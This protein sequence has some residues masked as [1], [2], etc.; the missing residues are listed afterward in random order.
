MEAFRHVD[1]DQTIVFGERALE[2]AGD[3]CSGAGGGDK[4]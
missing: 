4:R 1:R 3:L 2:A